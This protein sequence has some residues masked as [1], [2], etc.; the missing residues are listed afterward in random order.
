LFVWIGFFHGCATNKEVGMQPV[1]GASARKIIYLLS[2][3]FAILIIIA[4]IIS[5]PLAYY[6]MRQWSQNYKY[7]IPLSASTFI[8]AIISSIIIARITV[9]H[10]Q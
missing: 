4:F 9:A 6:I 10:R 1:L 7:R 5:A 3:E 2:K 8:L